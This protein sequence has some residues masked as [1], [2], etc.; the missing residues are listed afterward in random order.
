[1]RILW[2]SEN[3]PLA[4]LILFQQVSSTMSLKTEYLIYTIQNSPNQIRII[5]YLYSLPDIPNKMTDG[6][7]D[8]PTNIEKKEYT[9]VEVEFR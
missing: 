7:M 9:G 3:I 8:F 2:S 5:R 6:I 1:M 4:S